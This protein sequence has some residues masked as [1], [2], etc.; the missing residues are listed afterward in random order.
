M[1]NLRNGYYTRGYKTET[2]IGN[3]TGMKAGDS[4]FDTTNSFRRIYD[5]N[6]WVSGNQISLETRGIPGGLGNQLNGSLSRPSTLVDIAVSSSGNGLSGTSDNRSNSIGVLQTTLVG[7]VPV[8]NKALIQYSNIANI[9]CNGSVT[10]G[11]YLVPSNVY[12]LVDDT[13]TADNGSLGIA[14]KNT[15]ALNEIFPIF[16]RTI[17]TA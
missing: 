6:N 16:I 8:G 10:R 12:G 14:L 13:T 9:Q 17:D 11:R 5:G 15:S 7:G 4:V 1:G 3:L 2:E